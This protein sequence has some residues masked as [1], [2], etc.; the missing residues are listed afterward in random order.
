MC[1][2][3]L[4]GGYYL[5]AARADRLAPE[6]FAGIPWSTGEVLARTLDRCASLGLA[7]RLLPAARDVDTPPD[8]AALSRRLAVGGPDCPRTRALLARWGRLAGEPTP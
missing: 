4:V 3:D 5:I 6:L 8:L 7:F 2:S 1:S